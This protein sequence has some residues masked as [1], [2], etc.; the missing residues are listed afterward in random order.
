MTGCV[1]KK[2]FISDVGHD[3]IPD[4]NGCRDHIE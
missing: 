4:E 1:E 2:H 3:Y